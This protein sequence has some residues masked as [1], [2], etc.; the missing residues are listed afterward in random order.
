MQSQP[1]L[2]FTPANDNGG[3]EPAA[4]AAAG[5]WDDAEVIS[6]YT[7]E[8]ALEDGVLVD[9]RIG[10]FAGL[11]PVPAPVPVVMTRALFE[12]IRRAVEHPRWANDYRGVWHDVLWMSRGAVR[13]AVERGRAEFQVIITG[14]GRQRLHTLAVAFD[15]EAFTFMLEGED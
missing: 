13:L 4:A 5:F 7:R 15:G 8:Q 12:L 14:T 10:E 9:A 3:R 11:S 6:V 1:I 2:P